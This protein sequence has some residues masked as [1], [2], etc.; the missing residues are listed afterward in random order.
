MVV[1][2]DIGPLYTTLH[3]CSEVCSRYV[4]RCYYFN[5]GDCL[6]IFLDGTLSFYDLSPRPTRND[7]VIGGDTI[8]SC[9]D[10][11][12]CVSGLLRDSEL[13]PVESPYTSNVVHA[14]SSAEKVVITYTYASSGTYNF[15]HINLFFYHI[16][17]LGIGLPN[18]E[19]FVIEGSTATSLPYYITDNEDLTPEDS[20]RRDVTLSFLD[21][22]QTSRAYRI[23]FDFESTNVQWLV[24]SE[25]I[26]C[27]LPATGKYVRIYYD[28]ICIPPPS[29]SALQGKH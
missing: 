4:F 2:G 8:G 10:N 6:F 16:P 1:G 7:P 15:R 9:P 27:Q 18:I 3:Q 23:E 12:L 20:G 21:G 13:G 29:P 22:G 17:T 19:I 11:G 24:L 26:M 5:G 14:W 28:A 25:I